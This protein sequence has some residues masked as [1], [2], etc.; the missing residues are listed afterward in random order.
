MPKGQTQATQQGNTHVL[1]QGVT[2]QGTGAA[3]VCVL[4]QQGQ[5]AVTPGALKHTGAGNAVI[6][7]YLANQANLGANGMYAKGTVGYYRYLAWYVAAIG[8]KVN[9]TQ[10]NTWHQNGQ[11]LC[12]AQGNPNRLSQHALWALRMA[13]KN[14]AAATLAAN[15]AN[16]QHQGTQAS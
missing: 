15:A 8:G 4:T 9:T 10:G 5:A 1:V 11:P 3:T 7:Y 13:I 2:Y 12:N 14:H 6:A 16:Q